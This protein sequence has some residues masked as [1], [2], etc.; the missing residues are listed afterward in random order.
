MLS[1]SSVCTARGRGAGFFGKDAA[2]TASGTANT[3]NIGATSSMGWYTANTHRSTRATGTVQTMGGQANATT[4]ASSCVRRNKTAWTRRR[5]YE[6]TRTPS[7]STARKAPRT[8]RSARNVQKLLKAQTGLRL[9]G[10][11]SFQSNS[12]TTSLSLPRRFAAFFICWEIR[13][14]RQSD[15][16]R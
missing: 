9:Y 10:R 8:P 12:P 13:N 16:R 15:L 2:A 7:P 4:S 5:T 3:N 14:V 11:K 6:K 1:F